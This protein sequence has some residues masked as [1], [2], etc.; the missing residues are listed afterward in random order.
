M[1][2]ADLAHHERVYMGQ[3]VE[4]ATAALNIANAIIGG[5]KKRRAPPPPPP[6]VMAP[7][8]PPP[9]RPAGGGFGGGWLLPVAI[10]AGALGVLSVGMMMGGRGR[11]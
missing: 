7:P 4:A 1:Y 8:P 10:G 2:V 9:P 5:G 11:R 6:I 3:Y